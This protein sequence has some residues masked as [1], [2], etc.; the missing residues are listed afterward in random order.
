MSM[1]FTEFKRLLGAD[2]RSRDPEFLAARDAS[3]EHRAAS[4]EAE[5]FERRLE[6]ALALRAPE[7]LLEQLRSIPR[8][9]ADH[10]RSTPG[11]GRAWRFALAASLLIAVGAAGLTWKM[12]SGWDSVEDYVV[13]H[14]RHDGVEVLARAG[15]R[16]AD[17]TRAVLADFG[18]TA[19]PALAGAIRVIKMCPTPDG[20]GVHMV[21][22]TEHGL[23]TLIYMPHTA[24]SDGE[25]I[26]FDDSEALLVT[27]RSGSAVLIG[28]PSQQISDL[29]A[30]VQESIIPVGENT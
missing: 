2:P 20:K 19:L 30:L 10:G 23:V 13:D 11:R 22:D 4:A 7:D 24:V 1:G 12:N 21:L 9:S 15:G 29:R 17:D 25:R 14:F 28:S 3:P 16:T 8:S 27:L 6:Q 26:T 5:R 18:V